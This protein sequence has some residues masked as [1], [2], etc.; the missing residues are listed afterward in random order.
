MA[1]YLQVTTAVGSGDDAIEMANASVQAR[2]AGCAQVLGPIYSTYW[3][4]GKLE[5]AQEWLV[6]MKTNRELY[7]KL[8]EMI[9]LKHKYDVP[10]ILAT[11]VA[12]GS[13]AYLAWLDGE[14]KQ[15]K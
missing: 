10:E 5:S 3:W 14:L 11:P 6:M 8:E 9:R 12:T 1:E 7:P 13:P 4:Q 2:L 15:G